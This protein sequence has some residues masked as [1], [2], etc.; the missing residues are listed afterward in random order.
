RTEAIRNDELNEIRERIVVAPGTVRRLSVSVV[1][2]DDRLSQA[3]LDA[4]RA[5]VA[6][7]IGLDPDRSDQISVIG[8]AFDTSVAD[9]LREALA[10]EQEAARQAQRNRLYAAAAAAAL[11]LIL[12]L[13]I[14]ISVRRARAR[15]REEEVLRERLEAEIARRQ[16]AITAEDEEFEAARRELENLARQKPEHVAQIVRA[17]LV[18]E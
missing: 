17:W 15:R 13:V 16:E 12:G 5:T 10:A 9:S 4:V 7:A 8:M 11:V 14:L 3:Q 18:Q 1:I 2:N 6:A